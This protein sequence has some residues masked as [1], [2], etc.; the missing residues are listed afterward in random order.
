MSAEQQYITSSCIISNNAVYKDE[1]PVFG[2][3]SPDLAAFL[4][5]TYQ[6]FE[7]NYPKFYKMD[8]LSKLGWL[9]SEVLLKDSFDKTKYQ[10]EEIGIVLTNANSSLDADLKYWDSA[11]DMA[12][13]SLFVYTL[14][15]IVIGEICIRN[16]FKGED[17]FYITPAFDAAFIHQQASYLL[18]NDILKA[19]ICGWVDVVGDE[20]KAALFLVEQSSNG[21]EF[22]VNNLTKTFNI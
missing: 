9:A 8:N 4:L 15:N 16:G 17:A 10:P 13:P 12:S 3:Q 22:E 5:S 6:H 18:N 11:Q 1:M 7:L 21:V 2:G 20:Y 14:P 19:C